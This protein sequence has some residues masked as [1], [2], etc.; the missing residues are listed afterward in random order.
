MNLYKISQSWLGRIF[1]LIPLWIVFY[2]VHTAILSAI[3]AALIPDVNFSFDLF[4]EHGGMQAS[5][6]TIAANVFIACPLVFYLAKKYDYKVLRRT[7]LQF[8]IPFYITW[9]VLN[10]IVLRSTPDDVKKGIQ[11]RQDKTV[12][13]F[14]W[15]AIFVWA[16]LIFL[17]VLA[18]QQGILGSSGNI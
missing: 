15:I 5:I 16:W 4:P 2:M 3:N 11:L 7:I 14:I 9:F 17:F 10:A 13:V 1:V 8:L 18:F 6:L 12:L